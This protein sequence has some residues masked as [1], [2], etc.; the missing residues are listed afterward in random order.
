MTEETRN[1][2][3]LW[4]KVLSG[5]YLY[6]QEEPSRYIVIIYSIFESS[7]A[8][9]SKKLGNITCPITHLNKRA[10]FFLLSALKYCGGLWKIHQFRGKKNRNRKPT[11]KA[12]FWLYLCK[13]N[14]GYTCFARILAI[15]ATK[16]ALVFH[17][18]TLIVLKWR[19]ILSAIDLR[20]I[21]MLITTD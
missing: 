8:I 19:G 16:L 7:K 15:K 3:E 4:G 9:S 5:R 14:V 11:N 21:N 6:S 20:K 1:G 10:G 18:S 17:F 13:G 12:P 2:D